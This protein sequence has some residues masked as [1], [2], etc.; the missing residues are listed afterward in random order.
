MGARFSRSPTRADAAA[1]GIGQ[2]NA[3]VFG[4][5][6]GLSPERIQ[7]LELDKVIY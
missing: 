3:E 5:L 6:L 4:G 7:E 1:P 2:H